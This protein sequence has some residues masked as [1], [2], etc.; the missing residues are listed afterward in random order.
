MGHSSGENQ[1][2]VH[3][4]F[5]VFGILSAFIF[6]S[7]LVMI[8]VAAF[9]QYHLDDQPCAICV[10][11]RAAV[12]AM[13]IGSVIVMLTGNKG[14]FKSIFRS[15]IIL[16]PAYVFFHL[17]SE[18]YNIEAGLTFSM[19]GSAPFPEWM[20]L[21][22]LAPWFFGAEGMCGKSPVLIDLF[23]DYTMS[24]VL[25]SFSFLV[26]GC[27]TVAIGANYLHFI[28]SQKLLKGF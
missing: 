14:F 2:N 1:Y 21:H 18:A 23:P 10:Q 4:E 12:V 27:S 8:G 3:Y 15:A 28:V 20:P 25:S 6:C 11:I 22:D 19:C 16:A 17:S 7:S 9:F 5:R 13:L 24:Y 26:F